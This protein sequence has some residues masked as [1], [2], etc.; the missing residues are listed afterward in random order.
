[1]TKYSTYSQK[2]N[3]KGYSEMVSVMSN[4][5]AMLSKDIAAEIRK[6]AE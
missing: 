3:T 1:M 4:L 2:V 5:V 6:M